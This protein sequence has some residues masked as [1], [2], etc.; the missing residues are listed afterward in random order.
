[1][2]SK[3]NLDLMFTEL[4]AIREHIIETNGQV[5]RIDGKLEHMATKEDISVLHLKINEAIEEK[6][7]HHVQNCPNKK[8][9]VW[10]KQWLVQIGKNII[11]P[12]IFGAMIAIGPSFACERKN[13]VLV[14]TNKAPIVQV[15]HSD[16]I[17]GPK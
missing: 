9:Q 1:M 13:E 5:N 7:R 16:D 12:I 15:Q 2:N 4:R 10:S 17:G 14:N 8:P 6:V 11:A 3:D